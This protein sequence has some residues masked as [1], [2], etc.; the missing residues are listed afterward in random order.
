MDGEVVSLTEKGISGFGKLQADLK[1]GDH[2]A[3]VFFAFDLMFIDGFDLTYAPLSE[4]K[5]ILKAFLDEAKPDRIFYSEHF[6]DGVAL[7]LQV[8]KLGL[9]GVVSKL[10]ASKYKPSK[11][12]WKQVKCQQQDDLVILGYVSARRR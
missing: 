7:Y 8:E 12:A 9:E 6:E 3:I 2:S 11:S 5:R 1:N 4:R 10:A